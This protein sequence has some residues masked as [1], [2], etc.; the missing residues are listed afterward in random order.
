[1][2]I[3]P[4]RLREL[5]ELDDADAVLGPLDIADPLLTATHALRQL[6]LQKGA[7]QKNVTAILTGRNASQ[8]DLQFPAGR[9]R[10][11]PDLTGQKERAG[12]VGVQGGQQTLVSL[13]QA[14]PGPLAFEGRPHLTGSTFI[15]EDDPKMRNVI[16]SICADGNGLPFGPA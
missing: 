6:P 15:T 5:L 16:V 7:C 12:P 14:H 3:K 4:Q 11:Q 10:F 8:I 9:P 13:R 1:M 2:R